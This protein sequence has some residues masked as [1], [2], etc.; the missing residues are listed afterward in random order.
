[1]IPYSRRLVL[2]L[3]YCR[4]EGAEGSIGS[5]FTSVVSA[6][7][8]GFAAGAGAAAAAAGAAAFA[9]AS[10]AS[11]S[12]RRLFNFWTCSFKSDNSSARTGKDA[13]GRSAATASAIGLASLLNGGRRLG[14]IDFNCFL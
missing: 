3:V 10:L 9:A 1:M 5:P 8:T 2:L 6:T 4:T 14:S 7:G 13:R 12:D 11:R